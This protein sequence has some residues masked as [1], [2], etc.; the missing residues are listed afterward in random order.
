MDRNHTNKSKF[1][2]GISFIE[3]AVFHRYPKALLYLCMSCL[4]YRFGFD[5]SPN[6][7][8]AL[9]S[10]VRADQKLDDRA[11]FAVCLVLGIGTNPNQRVGMFLL[12]WY[13]SRFSRVAFYISKHLYYSE[14]I[15]SYEIL[16]PTI[17][18]E[19][20]ELKI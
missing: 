2:E 11:Y 6:E 15:R 5:K 18:D 3:K 16:D 20:P 7:L 12:V 10:A 19:F 1:Q 17:L 4:K 13:P 9:S 8:F 14:Y